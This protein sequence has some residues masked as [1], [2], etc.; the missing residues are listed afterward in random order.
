MGQI[1]I[2]PP[3]LEWLVVSITC[4]GV[5]LACLGKLDRK[6]RMN[7]WVFWLVAMSGSALILLALRVWMFKI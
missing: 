3:T 4:C 5:F 2:T 6:D 1:V 7:Y